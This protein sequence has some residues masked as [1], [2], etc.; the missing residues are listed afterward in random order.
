MQNENLFTIAHLSVQWQQPFHL[1]QKALDLVQAEPAMSL[2]G[3][4]YYSCDEER[5]ELLR[6]YFE[7]RR[8]NT[9]KNRGAEWSRELPI[10][11]NYRPT[12]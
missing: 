5:T 4:A 12:R 11:E 2:N 9:E 8:A 10:P 1:M 6:A 7:T 3:I